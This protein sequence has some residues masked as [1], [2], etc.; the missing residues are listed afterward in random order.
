MAFEATEAVL[1]QK[2]VAGGQH[3]LGEGQLVSRLVGDRDPPAQRADRLVEGVGIDRV[4]EDDGRVEDVACGPVAIG[5]DIASA[6]LM[7]KGEINQAGNVVAGQN[8]LD[9]LFKRRASREA[10]FSHDQESQG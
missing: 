5:T 8:R 6:G 1:N 7:D 10:T 4:G 2:L 3:G 9:R